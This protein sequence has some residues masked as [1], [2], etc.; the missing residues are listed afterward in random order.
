MFT[1]IKI[2]LVFYML[3]VWMCFNSLFLLN[4]DVHGVATLLT[5]LSTSTILLR[6]VILL[7]RGNLPYNLKKG[8]FS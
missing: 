8:I 5:Y 2:S 4:V 6:K 7:L 1:E 3:I